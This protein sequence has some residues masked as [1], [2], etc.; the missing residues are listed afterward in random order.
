MKNEKII[1]NNAHYRV[2]YKV[3]YRLRVGSPKEEG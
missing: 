2:R 1:Q 3:S